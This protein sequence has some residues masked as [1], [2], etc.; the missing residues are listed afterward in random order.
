MRCRP[1]PASD[2]LT[3]ACAYALQL[4]WAQQRRDAQLTTVP[5]TVGDEQAFNPFLR[6]HTPA[7]QAVRRRSP[8]PHC[9]HAALCQ[10]VQQ[11]VVAPPRVVCAHRLRV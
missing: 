7:L 8:S 6:V 11:A 3:L 10:C 2:V 9:Y 5:S 4:A 1:P